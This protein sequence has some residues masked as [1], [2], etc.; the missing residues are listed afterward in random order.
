LEYAKP[1][2]GLESNPGKTGEMFSDTHPYYPN[3]CHSCPFNKGIRNKAK[4]F[5][6]NEKKHCNECSKINVIIT[7]NDI[8][9]PKFE[10][11]KKVPNSRVYVSN[12]HG[13][14]EVEENTRLGKF[15]ET[16]LKTD[17]Y[18]LPRLDPKNPL[19]EKLRVYCIDTTSS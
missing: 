15:L 10:T 8:V 12:Y 13:K 5:F 14:N 9:P 18:L 4:S 16:K 19:E 3:S 11:Y 17:I 2:R 7:S 6:R 1:Q